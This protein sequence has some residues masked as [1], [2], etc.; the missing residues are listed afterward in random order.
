MNLF[1]A[2]ARDP[3]EPGFLYKEPL[4]RKRWLRIAIY[5]GL[6]VSLLGLLALTLF[7]R[8]L[9]AQADSYNLE[10]LYK[11]ETA[12]VIYDRNGKEIG[13]IYVENR[14]PVE[15]DDVPFHFIQ[16]LVAA[17]DS[18]YF[19]HHGVDYLGIARAM[20]HNLKKGGVVQ[21]GSTITQQLARKSFGLS[22]RSYKRKIVEAFLA[23]RIEEILT[24][25]QTMELYLNRIY[26]GSGFYGVNSAAM[27]Y[28]GKPAKDLNIEESATLCGLIKSPNRLSPLRN[29]DQSIEARNQVFLRMRN[30]KVISPEQYSALKQ[31]PLLTSPKAFE[32]RSSYVYQQ[33]RQLVIDEVGYEQ[34]ARGGFLIETTIDSDI[35]RAAEES[36]HRNLSRVET[37]PD[38]QHQTYAEYTARIQQL[39]EDGV[40]DI[41]PPEYLQGALLMIDNRTGAV[42]SMIGGREYKHSEFNRALQARRPPGTAFKPFLYATAFGNG[43]FP[44]TPVNDVPIDNR[45]VMIGGTQGILGEWGVETADNMHEGEITARRALV[46]SKVAA[47]ARLG[48]ALD[49]GVEAL[50]TTAK[51]AGIASPMREYPSSFLGSSELFLSELVTAYTVFPNGGVRSQPLYIVETIRD[52]DGNVVYRADHASLDPPETALDPISAFQA[53]TCLRDVLEKGTAGRARSEY[54]LEDFPAGGKT[55]TAYNFTD[56]CFVGYDSRVTCGVWTGFDKPGPIYRGAFSNDT[57]LP[58]W[59]DAMNASLESFPPG[60]IEPPEIAVAFEI[61]DRSGKPA[62]DSCYE[63]DIIDGR[64]ID[65]RCTHLEYLRPEHRLD[66]YCPIHGGGPPPGRI[67]GPTLAFTSP[68][69]PAR[70]LNAIEAIPMKSPTVLGADPYRAVTP[71]VRATVEPSPDENPSE[72]DSVVKPAEVIAPLEIGEEEFRVELPPPPAIE[73]D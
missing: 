50:I 35:Q 24:K 45:K 53:H 68:G 48:L 13:R 2:P 22:G 62:T 34:A 54:G 40:E 57:V 41:P 18:R 10:D 69:A 17:E 8:P 72:E 19:D 26:F 6:I 52:R 31:K 61:C 36:L 28:F 7:L 15:F 27:G 58:V 51:K 42:I 63:P 9:K 33:V 38:F 70:D 4:W 73:F 65:V 59:V 5:T 56:N 43:M 49:N 55:G 20:I 67:A 16:A 64:R 3:G 25:A 66:A 29:P 12:S 44:G 1:S 23:L 11:L 46:R 60:P 14:R 47:T 37:H 32:N 21:G 71:V 30:E 39:R